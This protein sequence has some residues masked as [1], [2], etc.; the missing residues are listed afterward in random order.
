MT[1]SS[2][3]LSRAET[4]VARH[5]PEDPG[6]HVAPQRT[7]A[8]KTLPEGK[9]SFGGNHFAPFS[10]GVNSCLGP[11]FPKLELE[12]KSDCFEAK[13][14]RKSSEYLDNSFPGGNWEFELRNQFGWESLM[15]LRSQDNIT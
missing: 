3:P 8:Y 14:I 15:F 7:G 10:K 4:W 12:L 13:K 6:S 1:S 2:K 11:L 9:T 5:L